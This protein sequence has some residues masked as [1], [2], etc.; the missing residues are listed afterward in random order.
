MPKIKINN[1]D[2]YYELHGHGQPI[3]L[4]SGYS[5]DHTFWMPILEKLS[6]EFQV[7]LFDNRGIGQTQDDG[8]EL[9]ADLLANDVVSLID[10]LNLPKPHII[11][12][13][14]GGTIAQRVATNYPDRIS[15]LVIITSTAK[16]RQAALLGLKSILTLRKNNLDFD[17]IANALLPWLFGEDFL[18]DKNKVQMFKKLILEDPHPQSLENQIRQFQILEK[19]NG[20][21]QLNKIKA[22]TLIIHGN[23][24]ILVLETESILLA[25]KISN[26]NLITLNSAHGVTLESPQELANELIKF[27][28]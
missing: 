15:K 13:S 3:V 12:Q 4:I 2:F 7:L 9:S 1:C 20:L 28:N 23:E 6:Q 22:P 5:C 8:V 19:F 11:G 24:D 27:L 14:M 17:I 26:A 25:E 10:I 16:W 21:N 18:Q